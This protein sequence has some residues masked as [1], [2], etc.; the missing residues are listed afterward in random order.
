MLYSIDGSNN[1]RGEELKGSGKL[2]KCFKDS[3]KK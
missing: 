3:Y 1:E 2:K